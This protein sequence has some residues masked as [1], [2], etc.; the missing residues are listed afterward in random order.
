MALIRDPSGHRQSIPDGIASD[1]FFNQLL[2]PRLGHVGLRVAGPPVLAQ[3]L[4][5]R[6]GAAY[7]PA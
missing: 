6:T 3:Q 5:R 7:L 4:C 1:V 2:Q